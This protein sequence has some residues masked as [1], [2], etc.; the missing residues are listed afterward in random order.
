[1]SLSRPKDAGYRYFLSYTDGRKRFRYDE[2]PGSGLGFVP[3][4]LVKPWLYYQNMP[5]YE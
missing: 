3:R 4:F 1:M 5:S 2:K